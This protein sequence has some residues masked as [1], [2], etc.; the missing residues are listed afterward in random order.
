MNAAIEAVLPLTAAQRGIYLETRVDAATYLGQLVVEVRGPVDSARIAQAWLEVQQ[1]H[2]GLRSCIG[3]YRETQ[4][5]VIRAQVLAG[6]RRFDLRSAGLPVARAEAMHICDDERRRGIDI[7]R[8]PLAR[9]TVIDVSPNCTWLCLTH[10]HIGLDG[11]SVRTVLADLAARCDAAPLKP[12]AALDDLLRAWPEPAGAGVPARAGEPLSTF[13]IAE[14]TRS[15]VGRT[16]AADSSSIREAARRSGTSPAVLIISAWMC[17]LRTLRQTD[18]TVAP[19]SVD[20]RPAEI[21]GSGRT[22]GMLTD[23]VLATERVPTTASPVVVAGLM[24]ERL[25]PPVAL[26]LLASALERTRRDGATGSPDTLLTVYTG[27]LLGVSPAGTGWTLVRASEPTE[28]AVDATLLLTDHEVRCELQL[29]ACRVDEQTA[30]ELVGNLLHFLE[31]PAARIDGRPAASAARTRPG[32]GTIVTPGLEAA[33]QDVVRSV[34]GFDP[35]VDADLYAAG[36]DSLS[37]LAVAVALRELGYPVGVSA[38][39][40]SGTIRRTALYLSQGPSAQVAVAQTESRPSPLEV[41]YLR[42]SSVQAIGSAPMHEQSVL[43]F[44]GH[45][46]PVRLAEAFC[47]CLESLPS[48]ARLWDRPESLTPPDLIAPA[49]EVAGGHPVRSQDGLVRDVLEADLADTFLPDGRGLLRLVQVPADTSTSLVLS[50]HHAILDG[51]SFATFVRSLQQRHETPGCAIHASDANLYRRWALSMEHDPVGLTV[52]LS[53]LA[54]VPD[55]LPH[56]GTRESGQGSAC[57][58]RQ[59]VAERARR[60]GGSQTSVLVAALALALRGVLAWDQAHPLG[61]RATVRDGSARADQ[62]TVGQLTVDMPLRRH[63]DSVDD[64]VAAVRET[65]L[66]V[67][68]YGHLGQQE[69]SRVLAGDR[70]TVL[71]LDTALVLENYFARDELAVRKFDMAAWP[72]LGS[73]RRDVSGTPRTVTVGQA[74]EGWTVEVTSTID[75]SPQELATAIAVS[76]V[77][78]LRSG[79]Q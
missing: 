61:L 18:L 14:R 3:T 41:G 57:L 2:A 56:V 21:A 32:A 59:L 36:V 11:A 33:V 31:N 48:L 68:R 49:F 76:A 60:E 79:D 19:L 9:L 62:R 71:P 7:V 20:R 66:A 44:A 26:P 34:V 5:L 53:G 54:A 73:W 65:V 75:Q 28:F 70:T 24:A 51:W 17:A 13:S 63:G 39:L 27:D 22:V 10:H 23:T 55:L 58:P 42:L 15:L 52:H 40:E 64:A 1:H 29:D 4:V 45:L 6:A 77:D 43:T 74:A 8:G 37:L 69:I 50:F 25:A 67:H 35:G 12:T 38:L 46:D 78:V 16:C 30:G 47:S 72:E